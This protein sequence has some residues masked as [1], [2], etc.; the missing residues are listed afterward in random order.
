VSSLTLAHT[1]TLNGPLAKLRWE[2]YSHSVLS[3]TVLPLAGQVTLPTILYTNPQPTAEN[4]SSLPPG[5]ALSSHFCSQ[6]CLA[7]PSTLLLPLTMVKTAMPMATAPLELVVFWL[8]FC[9][10]LLVDLASSASS[11]SLSQLLETI[12]PISTASP[13]LCKFWDDGL[14]VFHASSG[15]ECEYLNPITS[16]N[17]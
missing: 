10:R 13:L 2:T 1:F 15:S 7:L 17:S 16:K 4:S 3:S 9:F 6:K 8:L 12:F 14:S 5:S 11:F